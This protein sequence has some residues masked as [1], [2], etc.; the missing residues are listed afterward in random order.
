MKHTIAILLI[1]VLCLS[2]FV[3]PAFADGNIS[4]FR[5]VPVCGKYAAH[6]ML[7]H[8]WGWVVD[9]NGKLTFE[10]NCFQCTRCYHIMICQGEPTLGQ[11]IGTYAV[12][13]EYSEIVSDLTEIRSNN[14]HYCGSSNLDGYKFRDILT[15]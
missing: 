13:D 15:G 12:S 2:L 5:Y 3:S 1:F 6:D 11:A 9:S 14:L 8:G 7:S 4:Q 10:G